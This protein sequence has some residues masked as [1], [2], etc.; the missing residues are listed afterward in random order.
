MRQVLPPDVMLLAE[1][2][3]EDL[4]SALEVAVQRVQQLDPLALHARVSDTH[5]LCRAEERLRTRPAAVFS[6]TH[7]HTF[8][9]AR[10]LTPAGAGP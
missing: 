5:V 10:L 6:R 7:L 3:P 1:P 9:H 8:P 2:C 4:L